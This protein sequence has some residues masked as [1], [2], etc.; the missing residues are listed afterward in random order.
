MAELS[1][2]AKEFQSLWIE[3]E[4][5]AMHFND[6][7]MRLRSQG[8]AGIAAVSTLMGIFTKGATTNIAAD[9]QIATAIF[10]ALILFWVAIGFLDLLYYN[11][12]LMGA[13]EAIVKLEAQTKQDSETPFDGI[14]MST[15]IVAE[16]S[17]WPRFGAF[18]GVLVFYAI[19]LFTIVGGACFSWHQYLFSVA[20]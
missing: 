17:R 10:I 18:R 16:F 15:Y 3:Y 19:V 4:K 11:R 12:L 1:Q 7:L 6:L 8:L 13:V 5:I 20:R 2:G 14:N 9:W